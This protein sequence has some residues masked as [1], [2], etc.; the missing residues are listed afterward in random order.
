MRGLF[1][2]N[3]IIPDLLKDGEIKLGN[4]E[5]I[6]GLG[7][8]THGLSYPMSLVTPNF[9]KARKVLNDKDQ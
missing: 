1:L 3:E 2:V 4:I 8:T 7:T 6:G 9:I 5:V